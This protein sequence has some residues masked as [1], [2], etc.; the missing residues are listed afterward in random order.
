VRKREGVRGTTFSQALLRQESWSRVWRHQ[1]LGNL[2][3]RRV[4]GELD[5]AEVNE[6]LRSA[7]SRSVSVGRSVRV[8][9]P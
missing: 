3:C 8:L 5:T 4:R 1:P 6:T 9:T 2:G 7:R